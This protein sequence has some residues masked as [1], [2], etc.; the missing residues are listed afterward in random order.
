MVR[1]SNVLSLD[2][3]NGEGDWTVKLEKGKK[4]RY[5]LVIHFNGDT[6]GWAVHQY[7]MVP[8]LRALLPAERDQLWNDRW[9][10]LR[11]VELDHFSEARGEIQQEFESLNNQGYE[12]KRISSGFVLHSWG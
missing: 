12:I 3:I 7:K 4:D 10:K 8:Y 9:R 6:N 2:L 11:T 5:G 1:M